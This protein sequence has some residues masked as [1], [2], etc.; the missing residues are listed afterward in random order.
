MNRYENV[1]KSESLSNDE[2]MFKSVSN[3]N[4][5]NNKNVVLSSVKPQILL[6][7]EA[8][9]QV[10]SHKSTNSAKPQNLNM[11]SLKFTSYNHNN[12]VQEPVS[13]NS[14]PSQSQRSLPT[15]QDCNSSKVRFKNQNSS[16][17]NIKGSCSG[18]NDKYTSKYKKTNQIEQGKKLQEEG[19]FGKQPRAASNLVS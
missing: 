6:N 4:N 3:S 8:S 1:K 16:S 7:S 2:K 18:S 14:I 19:L 11:K 12:V 10:L 17:S 15:L 5:S 13:S 9:K